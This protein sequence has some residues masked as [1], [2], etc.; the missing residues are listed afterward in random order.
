MDEQRFLKHYANA[1]RRHVTTS[2]QISGCTEDVVWCVSRTRDE[3]D[4]VLVCSSHCK[5][6]MNQE[7]MLHFTSPNK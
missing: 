4:R 6:L 3:S 2:C 1:R 5:A 7:L